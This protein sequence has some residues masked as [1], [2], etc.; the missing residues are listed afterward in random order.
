MSG[1]ETV[2][3]AERVGADVL[4]DCVISQKSFSLPTVGEKVNVGLSSF[5]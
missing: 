2:D 1:Y 5:F 3:V 4:L